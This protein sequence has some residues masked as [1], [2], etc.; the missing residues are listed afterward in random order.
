ME[1]KE[2]ESFRWIWSTANRQAHITPKSLENDSVD[3]AADILNYELVC[4]H[5]IDLFSLS[6]LLQRKFLP[7]VNFQRL[8]PQNRR[9][10]FWPLLISRIEVIALFLNKFSYT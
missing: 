6:G 1:R 8:L 9:V 4:L 10:C 7:C 5:F 2:K 3:S